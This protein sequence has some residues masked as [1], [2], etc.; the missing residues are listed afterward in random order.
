VE[1]EDRR[2]IS[3]PEGVD[4]ELPLGG[5]GSRFLGFL[6]DTLIEGVT[7]GIVFI[8]ALAAGSE[9]IAVI[10]SSAALLITIGYNV[11]FEVRGGGRTLGKRAVGTRVVMS[12]GE[13]VGLRASLIRNIVRLLE[14][15]VPLIPIIS[16]LAT[17]SNQRLG[18]IAG[19]T[20]VIRDKVVLPTGYTPALA[21]PSAVDATAV[22]DEQLAV[23]RAFLARRDSLAPN[24]RRA[25]AADLAA[26]LRPRVAGTRAGTADEPLLEQIAA[27]KA[28]R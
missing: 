16:I 12:G 2:T 1:Y 17:R 6:L 11:V 5:L 9:V 8:A 19:G 20:L 22:T 28:N 7:I 13:P 27:A 23:V 25:I 10:V 15:A 26:T 3:T 14:E 4:L 21:E 18:D 24:A